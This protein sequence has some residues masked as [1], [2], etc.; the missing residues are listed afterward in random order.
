MS[1]W[2]I[3]IITIVTVIIIIVI[4]HSVPVKSNRWSCLSDYN[5]SKKRRGKEF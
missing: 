2:N 3:E 1:T 5:F 4:L